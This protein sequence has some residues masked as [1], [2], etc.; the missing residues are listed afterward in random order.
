[1]GSQKKKVKRKMGKNIDKAIV[2]CEGNFGGMDGKTANGLVRHSKKYKIIGVIDSSKAGQ[3][4]GNILDSSPNGIMIYKDIIACLK[5]MVKKIL[6]LS[7]TAW[8]L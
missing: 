2:Y 7:F 1:M 5:K 3:D 8:R 6:R 4:T